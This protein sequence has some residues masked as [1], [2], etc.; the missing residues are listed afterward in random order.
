AERA[1]R[2]RVQ[3]LGA[4]AHSDPGADLLAVLH[5]RYADH[6][7]VGD[8]GVGVEELLDLAR[9]N[10][11]PAPDHHVLDPADDVEVAV[12][13]HLG[14][15]TGVHPAVSV[16]RLG[17]QVRLLPVPQHHRVPARTELSRRPPGNGLSAHR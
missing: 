12:G 9:V 11:L 2:I 13:T 8:V 7:D 1:D 17:G 6:L 16:D 14:Q 15:I 5:I 3:R 4:F 10:V